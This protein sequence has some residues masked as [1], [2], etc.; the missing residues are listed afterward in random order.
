MDADDWQRNSELEDV[1]HEEV[2]EHPRYGTIVKT[3]GKFVAL[4]PL[5]FSL[6]PFDSSSSAKRSVLL[7]YDVLFSLS[8]NFND[9]M[10]KYIEELRK[11]K[12]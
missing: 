6:G 9:D 8:R 1:D 11:G 10:L 7:N 5:I 12:V 2:W 4:V 3:A